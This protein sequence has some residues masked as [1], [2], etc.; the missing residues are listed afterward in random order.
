MDLDF[1]ENH[2]YLRTDICEFVKFA[3]AWLKLKWLLGLV[4]GE[5]STEGYSSLCDSPNNKTNL[6]LPV[7]T[8]TTRKYFT[9]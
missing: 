5:R 1:K 4:G 6:E 8:F 3:A 7:F 2:T 9:K